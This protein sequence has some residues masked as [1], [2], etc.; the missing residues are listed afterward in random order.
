LTEESRLKNQITTISK[1]TYNDK[2][3]LVLNEF[4]PDQSN[5]ETIKNEIMYD[6]KG[7]IIEIKEY[8]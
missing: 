5:S 3:D 2:G 6:E 1:Y 8:R 4:N 7:D